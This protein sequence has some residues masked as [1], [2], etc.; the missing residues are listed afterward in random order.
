MYSSQSHIIAFDKYFGNGWWKKEE[1]LIS[2]EDPT[3]SSLVGTL[4]VSLFKRTRTSKTGSA[5]CPISFLY[6]PDV[7]RLKITI[8]TYYEYPSGLLLRGAKDAH[9]STTQGQMS[10]L[11]AANYD[12]LAELMRDFV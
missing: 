12:T 7:S 2:S 3:Q 11:T 9:H 10:N 1:I 4:Y 6:T 5:S 8:A